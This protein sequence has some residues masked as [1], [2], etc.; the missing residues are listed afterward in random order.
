M[1]RPAGFS[2][3]EL[4]VVIGIIG[5]LAALLLPAL[6]Q[7]R[8]AA[9]A[10]ACRSNLRQLHF[11]NATYSTDHGRFAP[12]AS[13]IFGNNLN[14]WYGAR[15]STGVP[16]DSQ[17]GPLSPYLGWS[18]A[19]RT[20]AAMSR[21]KFLQDPAIAY[22]A[23]CGGYGYN[24]IGVG[25]RSYQLGYSEP[26]SLVGLRPEEITRAADAVMFAD[27]AFPYFSAGQT[28][29]IEYSFAEP[30]RYINA[31]GVLYATPTPSIHFRH[32]NR[33]NVVWADGHATPEQFTRTDSAASRRYLIGWFGTQ[34]DN[35]DFAPF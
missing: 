10:V 32:H 35:Y 27:T 6:Q 30:D 1:K 15:V 31:A 22:E 8:G 11:A 9:H 29:L 5:L 18:R 34:T 26:A 25:S 24:S 7:A 28:H 16:F 12:A 3:I 33:A 14:R 19:I 13:D 23:G 21:W 2:L 20:C 17:S 4:L